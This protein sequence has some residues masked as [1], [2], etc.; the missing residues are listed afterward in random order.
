MAE[1]CEVFISLSLSYCNCPSPCSSRT[2][3]IYFTLPLKLTAIIPIR[4]L[5]KETLCVLCE[6]RFETL[7][8]CRLRLALIHVCDLIKLN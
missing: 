5:L 4:S 8:K 2:P 3:S 6:V 1:Y 7:C